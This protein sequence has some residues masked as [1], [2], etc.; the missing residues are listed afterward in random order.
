MHDKR[1]T[2]NFEELLHRYKNGTCTPKEVKDLFGLLK[3]DDSDPLIDA[4]LK[5][6]FDL[7]FDTHEKTE[8]LPAKVFRLPAFRKFAVASAAS[9]VILFALYFFF[10]TVNSDKNIHKLVLNE[11]K[12]VTDQKKVVLTID[13]G[14]KFILDSASIGE[15]T[16]QS[17][18]VISLNKNGELLYDASNAQQEDEIRTNT[19]STPSGG[20]FKIVLPDGTKVWLNSESE[21]T[22]PSK[23][24]GTVRNVTLKGEG[25][26]EVAK[27]K[28]KPF[29]VK[30]DRGEEIAVLGTIFNVMA[31]KNEPI[32]KITL[33]EGSIRV[34]N[35]EN[36]KILKP[37]QLALIANEEM[38]VNNNVP[39]EH[40]IA[41]KNGFF[42]FQNDDLY[43]IMR[44]I[45]RWYNME[46]IYNETNLNGHFTGSMRKSAAIREV[47]KMLEVAGDI[48]FS[49]VGNKILVH[50]KK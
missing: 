12:K 35:K 15:I 22:F 16:V 37:G 31:Y 23:F 1:N 21:L 38:E 24:A 49:I 44:Q 48:S 41:W 30:L 4:E 20:F 5:K 46:I 33:L 13:N 17:G 36:S 25:Y 18:I 43:T 8:K 2:Q 9:I 14:K 19:V 39:I 40:E 45:S 11:V 3:S 26:F 50:E 10:S 29:K 34:S 42:D 7:L 28:E 47:I 27:N 32:Q 6:E